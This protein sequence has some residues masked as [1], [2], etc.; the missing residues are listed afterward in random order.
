MRPEAAWAGRAGA[1]A[2][3]AVPASA[4]AIGAA[5]PAISSDLRVTVM[6]IPSSDVRGNDSVA[7]RWG[8]SPQHKGPRAQAI[9]HKCSRANRF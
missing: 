4:P 9:T 2:A 3:A 6:V 1:S 5:E 8:R 7:H